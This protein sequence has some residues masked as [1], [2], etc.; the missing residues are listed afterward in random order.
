MTNKSIF[1][2]GTSRVI[3][4]MDSLKIEYDGSVYLGSFSTISLNETS[5]NP[6]R[7]EYN[8]EFIVSSFGTDLMGNQ[9]DGHVKKNNNDQS[10][11]VT[12]AFQGANVRMDQ[13]IG[14]SMTEMDNFF[15]QQ[16]PMPEDTAYTADEESKEFD[17]N[18]GS[19]EL[20]C[21]NKGYYDKDHNDRKTCARITKPGEFVV[22]RGWRDTEDHAKKVA[23]RT[24]SGY[25]RSLTD[26]VVHQVV[27]QG[28]ERKAY[29]YLV[30]E[31]EID[32]I[33]VYVRY[34]HLDRD[35]LTASG[36]KPKDKINIGD[37]IST[38][39]TDGH[40]Y[41]PHCDFEVRET[42]GFNVNYWSAK[43]IEAGD[44]LL[45]G[46]LAMHEKFVNDPRGGAAFN[47]YQGDEPTCKHGKKSVGGGSH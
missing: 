15:P 27:N 7:L 31:S 18:E 3:N 32:G 14:I 47:D 11:E 42:S 37:V 13:R 17:G 43:R 24:G 20:A 29:H 41:P 28:Y 6:F 33:K 1:K 30:V 40:E 34:F 22:T 26:G 25:I 10:N 9:I 4:V 44:I 46:Y 5:E 16:E 39:G 21:G 38:E 35:G 8:F 45:A 2:D 23:F 36:F 19:G 12:V